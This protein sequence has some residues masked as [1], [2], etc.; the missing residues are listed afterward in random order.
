MSKG[1]LL[2]KE[3]IMRIVVAVLMVLCT[4]VLVSCRDLDVG[5]QLRTYYVG[6]DCVLRVSMGTTAEHDADRGATGG[7]QVVTVY[8][9]EKVAWCNRTNHMITYTVSDPKVLG[10]RR[11][12]R[13]APGEC[14]TYH[15]GTSAREWKLTWRC[16]STA[17]GETVVEGGGASPGKTEDP[18]PP[19]PPTGP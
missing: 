19:P 7:V 14:V 2:T 8:R 1:T 11:T 13:L 6:K 10:G 3:A 16:W 17:G 12:I 5:K 15:V 4:A 18:P 9:G